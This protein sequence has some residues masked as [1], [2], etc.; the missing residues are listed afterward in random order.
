MSIDEKKKH[1]PKDY[2]DSS[3]ENFLLLAQLNDDVIQDLSLNLSI[4]L[5][6]THTHT[7][8]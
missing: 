7:E 2:H 6:L 3:S 4:Y 8:Q 1:L 5:S